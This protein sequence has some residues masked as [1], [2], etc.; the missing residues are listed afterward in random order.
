MT[1]LKEALE[2]IG[3]CSLAFFLLGVIFLFVWY[4][5]PIAMESILT[6]IGSIIQ[7]IKSQ[8]ELGKGISFLIGITLFGSFVG[9]LSCLF[10]L[11]VKTGETETETENKPAS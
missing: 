1:K 9:I 5:V 4:V 2:F 11:N 3:L 8:S 7:F 10:D 6:Y